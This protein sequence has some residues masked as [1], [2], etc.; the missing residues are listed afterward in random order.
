[1]ELKLKDQIDVKAKLKGWLGEKRSAFKM[2]YS[3]NKKTYQRYHDLILTSTNGTT[4]IDHLVVSVYGLFLIETKNRKGWIYGS[5]DQ[6]NWT[7]TLF[8]E[9][10]KFQNPLHQTFRQ[11]KVLTELLNVNENEI[12]TIIYFN[13]NCDFKTVVPKNVIK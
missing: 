5:K 10:Y 7:Q 12:F 2:W 11:K 6:S 8:Q 3:L 13:G 9:K 4:Q 1:M